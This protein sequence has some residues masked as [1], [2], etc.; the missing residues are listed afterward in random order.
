MSEFK[1]DLSGAAPDLSGDVADLRAARARVRAE[2]RGNQG[3]LSAARLL[4]TL[5]APLGGPAGVV[6]AEVAK[7]AIDVALEPGDGA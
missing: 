7:M 5:A 3:L 1:S 6:A 4:V 2:M